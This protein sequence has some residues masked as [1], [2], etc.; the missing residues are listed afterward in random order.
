MMIPCISMSADTTYKSRLNIEHVTGEQMEKV[1]NDLYKI[2]PSML[3]RLKEVL[4]PK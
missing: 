4:L 1:V 2:E 3:A